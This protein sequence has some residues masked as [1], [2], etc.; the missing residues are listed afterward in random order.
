MRL[1]L[2]YVVSGICKSLRQNSSLLKQSTI[3]ENVKYRYFHSSALNMVSATNTTKTFQRLPKAVKPTNYRLRLQPD[4]KKF[5]FAGSSEIEVSVLE[6]TNKIV[7]NSA[8]LTIHQVAFKSESG[9]NLA[10]S[11]L[12][13]EADETAEFTFPE[14]LPTGNGVLEIKYDGILNDKL[15]GFYRSK[16]TMANGEERYAAVTQ[17]ESTDA[18]RA[19]P[20]WDEPAIKATFD[21]TLVAPKD[22]VAL[23]NMPAK[24]ETVEGDIKI[25]EYERTPIVSTYLIAFIVGDFE[26]IEAK[27]SNGVLVRVFTQIGKKEQGRFALDVAVKTLP[28]YKV[29]F[30]FH[31]SILFNSMFRIISTS[32]I[33]FQKW[34]SL[35]FLILRLVPWKTGV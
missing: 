27:D 20:C 25:T 2:S 16:Y 23:S 6:S 31:F 8:D 24:K 11:V 28:F 33:H 13:N 26:H 29:R 35:L 22:K 15:K 10:A 21:V 5:S 12:L 1:V 7:L 4:L 32:D 14:V 3:V 18:R 34:T 30:N 19:F 17:F 9:K